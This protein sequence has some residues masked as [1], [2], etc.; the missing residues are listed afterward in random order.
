[1]NQSRLLNPGDHFEEIET[2][3]TGKIKEFIDKG[4]IDFEFY[5]D[6]KQNIKLIKQVAKEYP[7]LKIKAHLAKH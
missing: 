7:S 1:M 4:F 5:D 2:G 6:D 3:I